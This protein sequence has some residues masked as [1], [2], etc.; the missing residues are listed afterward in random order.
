MWSPSLEDVVDRFGHHYC[1]LH[2]WGGGGEP[3]VSGCT[4]ATLDIL[5]RGGFTFYKHIMLTSPPSPERLLLSLG[6]KEP[7]N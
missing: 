6:D 2:G 4:A 5:Q 1:V 7:K 3:R